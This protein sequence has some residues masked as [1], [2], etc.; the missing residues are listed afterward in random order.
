MPTFATRRQARTAL[1]EPICAIHE[2]LAFHYLHHA[3]LQRES[4]SLILN[5]LDIEEMVGRALLNPFARH[6]LEA[7]DCQEALSRL[8]NE[9]LEVRFSNL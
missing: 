3:G 9:C 4:L 8:E 6:Y 2:L 1:M 7:E 5:A